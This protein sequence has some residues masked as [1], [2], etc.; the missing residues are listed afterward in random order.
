[1]RRA[2]RT[3]DNHA[4]IVAAFRR[5]G[6]SVVSLAA[7]GKG[8]PDLLCA[9]RTGSWL[10]EVKDGAKPPSAR[11]LTPD[12]VEFHAGWR[13]EIFVVEHIEDVPNVIRQASLSTEGPWVA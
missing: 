8:C 5:M 4:A 1:M 9:N 2:A 10:V 12:Q 3:D 11:Q 6:C 7:V 13:G